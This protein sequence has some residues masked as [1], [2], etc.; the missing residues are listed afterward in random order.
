MS[1]IRSMLWSGKARYGAAAFSIRTIACSTELGADDVVETTVME[2][3]SSQRRDA[4]P[5]RPS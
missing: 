3:I 4:R 1:A 5:R 2:G